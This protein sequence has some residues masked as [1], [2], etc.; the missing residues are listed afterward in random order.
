MDLAKV[1]DECADTLAEITGLR[2]FSHPPATITPPA[3]VV[4]YPERIV[5]DATYARGMDIIEALPFILLAGKAT[6]RAARDAVAA[7]AAGA[8][9]QSVKV[10]FERKSWVAFEDV[11]VTECSFDVVTIAGVDYMAAMFKAN[12]AGSGT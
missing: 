9:D 8:G 10:R 5:Y 2:V 1:M 12:I 4:S 3:G 11:T 7:W 6:D